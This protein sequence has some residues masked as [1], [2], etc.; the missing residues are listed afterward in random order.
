MSVRTLSNRLRRALRDTDR[1]IDR[2]VSA[3]LSLCSA[4]GAMRVLGLLDTDAPRSRAEV[5]MLARREL[6]EVA[7]RLGD[8]PGYAGFSEWLEAQCEA[9]AGCY[10]MRDDD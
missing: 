7:G 2:V 10:G 1:G 4:L 6:S 9:L 3:R 8:V 5:R